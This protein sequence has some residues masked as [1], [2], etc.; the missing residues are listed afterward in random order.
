MATLFD[1]AS[2]VM[3]PSGIKESKLYSV[4]PIDGSGDFV[5]SRGSDIQATRRNTSGLIE[6][7]RENFFINSNAP[8]TQTITIVNASVYVLS[9]KGTGSVALSGGHS[10]TLSGTGVNDRVQLFFVSSSTSVIL[11]ISGTITEPQLELGTVA[12]NYIETAATS[13]VAGITENLPR[14]N[15]E[16]GSTCARLLMEESRTQLIPQSEFFGTGSGWSYNNLSVVSNSTTSPDGSAN[17]NKVIIGTSPTGELRSATSSQAAG[18]YAVSMF[19]KSGDLNFSVLQYTAGSNYAR[20]WFDLSAGAVGGNAVSGLTLGT[21]TIESYANGWYRC[22][23]IVTTTATSTNRIVMFGATANNTFGAAQN[24]YFYAWGAQV[25]VN[26]KA[27]SYIP[28]Y[29]A[30]AIRLGDS[31]T[32]S[33]ASA[34]LNTEGVISLSFSL[35]DDKEFSFLDS[36][37]PLV[38]GVNKLALQYS[39]TILKVSLNGSIIIDKTGTYDTASLNSIELGHDNDLDQANTGFDYFTVFTTLLSTTELN[40]LTL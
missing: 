22:T 2:L 38:Q 4:K 32:L 17:A 35:D 36:V 14:L 34:V 15:Y 20:V 11:T 40:T 19:V 27:K 37:L 18:T 24:T 23:I 16:S 13:V 39:A 25:Q 21:S 8:V 12:S 26:S 3:I 30:T 6:K 31:A 1:Q 28:S 29:G 9:F 33:S 5:F 7:G 10:G